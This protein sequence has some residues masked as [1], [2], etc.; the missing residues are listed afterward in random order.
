[1]AASVADFF[2][3]PHNQELVRR[4]RAAGVRLAADGADGAPRALEGQEYVLTGRLGALTRG[5][6]EEAL[7]RRGAR[8]GSAVTR[9]T[10]AVVAGDDPGS[11]LARAQKLGVRVMD[12][13][14]LLALLD[15]GST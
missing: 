12:E 7:K 14:A 8:I 3:Q 9:K 6:A 13:A 15:D 2:A 11:K 10:T 1:M 5:E 4:L